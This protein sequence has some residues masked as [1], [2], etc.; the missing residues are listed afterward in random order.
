M[1]HPRLPV[2][3][4]VYQLA[5]RHPVLVARQLSS[6]S[7]L[8]PGRLVLGVGIGGEDRH[9]VA[10]CGVDP[11]TRGRRTNESLAILRRLLAGERVTHHGGH[12]DLDDAVANDPVEP[13]CQLREAPGPVTST[14]ETT[15]MI[16]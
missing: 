2:H 13:S 16:A 8:A 10:I 5:M 7:E 15:G 14:R 11:A 1:A 6:F 3:L 4:A 9:E 12:F